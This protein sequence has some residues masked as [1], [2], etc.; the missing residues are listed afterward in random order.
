MTLSL[1]IGIHNLGYAIMIENKIVSFGI[2]DIDKCIT[3]K[4]RYNIVTA[5]CKYLKMFLDKAF[6]KCNIT[7]VIIERQVNVNTKAMEIMYLI[8]GLIYPICND[9]IIFDPKQKFTKLKIPYD[10]TNKNHKKLSINMMSK[11]LS[12]R[13]PDYVEYY[14]Q[15]EKK[16]DISDAIFQLLIIN[17]EHDSSE[18]LFIRSLINSE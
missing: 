17:Y 15:F 16:D 4:E 11:Y 18:L 2:Y 8:T 3:A 13:Y 6:N 5:R 1:D 7:K 10:T 12:K 9:I 14:N